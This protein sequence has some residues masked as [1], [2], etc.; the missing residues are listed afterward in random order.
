MAQNG[1]IGR[2][3]QLPWH[4]SEDL[5]RFKKITMGHAIVMGRRTFES[6]G[7]PLPG[8]DNVIVSRNP[9]FHAVGITIITDLEKWLTQRS[10]EHEAFII[11][12]Q[13]LYQQ[14]LPHVGKLYVTWIEQDFAGDTVFP[15]L[16]WRDSFRI[17]SDSGLLYSEE[18]QLP[19]RFLE[20]L[21][22]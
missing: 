22:P 1:V 17:V 20:A 12:G 9:H 15:D 4:L 13:T 3:N 16:S 19:F 18:G 8:R 14:A 2:N 10:T 5:K 21:R 7:R 11:G 6:I